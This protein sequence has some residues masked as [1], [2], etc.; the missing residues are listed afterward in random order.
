MTNNIVHIAYIASFMWGLLCVHIVLNKASFKWVARFLAL[1]C[2]IWA[3]QYFLLA[4][5]LTG[6][7]DGASSVRAVLAMSLG[8]ALYFYYLCASEAHFSFRVWHLTHLIPVLL[9]SLAIV[10]KLRFFGALIDGFIIASL[11]TYSL[12]IVF[13]LVRLGGGNLEHL[14]KQAK[15]AY[16]WLWAVSGMM[17]VAVLSEVAIF[18]EMG[19]GTALHE[20]MALSVSA[21]IFLV[22]TAFVLLC[23]LRRSPL[24]EWMYGLGETQ[25]KKYLHSKL[26]FE[27]CDDY[28]T[29]LERLIEST[30]LYKEGGVKVVDVATQMNISARVLS[31]VL[32]RKR[33]LSFPQYINDFRVNEAKRLLMAEPRLPITD[34]MFYTGFSTKSNF[35]KAFVRCVG[36]SPSDYRKRT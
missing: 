13:E 33:G 35:N 26:T 14:G 29:Q 36:M 19:F 23:F 17:M 28:F 34:I 21:W 6:L 5:Q 18:I 27:Q 24:L 30:Q 2:F 12:G 7:F 10:A 11:S 9:V 4:A 20:S 22:F 8:P 1:N 3:V 32:N 16:L 31:E 15:D 25:R